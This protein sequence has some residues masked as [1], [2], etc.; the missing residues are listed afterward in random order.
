MTCEGFFTRV[1]MSEDESSSDDLDYKPTNIEL[2]EAEDQHKTK[3]QKID[4]TA[5]A[6][7][8]IPQVWRNS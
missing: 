5:N 7:T 3:R 2:Q 8:K 6:A 1:V 4:N